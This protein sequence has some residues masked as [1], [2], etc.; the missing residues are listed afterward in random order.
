MTRGVNAEIRRNRD[1]GPGCCVSRASSST[2]RRVQKRSGPKSAYG[3]PRHSVRTA[4]GPVVVQR[5]RVRMTKIKIV[6]RITSIILLSM[7][8]QPS[9]QRASRGVAWIASAL[10]GCACG[11]GALTLVYAEAFS[12]LSN[13]PAVCAN[14]HIMNEYLE[15]WR[16]GPHHHVAGCVDCHLPSALVAKYVAKAQ[17]GWHHSVGF[18]FQSPRPD[19][20]G[21]D[22]VF[23]E[24]I[25][26]QPANR[27]IL[28]EN[29]LRCH[30][31]LVHDIVPGR[32]G[33]IPCSHCHQTAGHGAPY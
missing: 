9:S 20:P 19:A 33:A 18:T 32:G 26:I 24:P 14:C 7:W 27:D 13:D 8:K 21:E 23:V 10:L 6:Y 11:I 31:D 12:Y 25:R 17:N 4:C 3:S 1:P 16:R 15:T 5:T 28:E 30:A 22:R 2:Q 29:C